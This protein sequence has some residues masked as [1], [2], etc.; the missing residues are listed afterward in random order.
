MFLGAFLNGPA[1]RSSMRPGRCSGEVDVRP[2]SSARYAP[3]SFWPWFSLLLVVNGY[4]P[5]LVPSAAVSGN[6]PLNARLAAQSPVGLDDP[7][8]LLQVNLVQ[9]LFDR[10]CDVDVRSP[11]LLVS[12]QGAFD[13]VVM[14]GAIVL[15][16]L[17][18]PSQQF[19]YRVSH[20]I[21]FL[22]S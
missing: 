4:C 22:L 13:P 21:A 9:A 8:D 15:Q 19:R 18:E 10:E 7:L 17:P 1:P 6:I 20:V 11:D 16:V 12:P 2:L 5:V 3:A 14:Q